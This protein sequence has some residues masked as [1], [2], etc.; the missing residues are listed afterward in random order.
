MMQ[1]RFQASRPPPLNSL[2][3]LPQPRTG[4]RP[5]RPAQPSTLGGGGRPDRPQRRMDRFRDAVGMYSADAIENPPDDVPYTS[6]VSQRTST[7]R[8]MMGIQQQQRSMSQLDKL[9]MA[10]DH[11]MRASPQQSQWDELDD[12]LRRNDMCVELMK[13]PHDVFPVA[14]KLWINLAECDYQRRPMLYGMQDGTVVMPVFTWEEYAN[15]FFLVNDVLESQW[16]PSPRM[17]TALDTFKKLEFPVMGHGNIQKLA[18]LATVALRQ[19][20]TMLI[21]PCMNVSKFLSYQEMTSL[22]MRR[23]SALLSAAS[24]QASTPSSTT[25]SSVATS[26]KAD[27]RLRI[28]RRVFDSR[29]WRGARLSAS[30]LPAPQTFRADDPVLTFRLPLIAS[31]EL[32]LRMFQQREVVRVHVDVVPVS[33]LQAIAASLMMGSPKA[34][35]LVITVVLDEPLNDAA[36]K[37]ATED[38]LLAWS[39]VTEES[40]TRDCRVVFESDNATGGPNVARFGPVVYE[41]KDNGDWLS[42]AVYV[43]HQ[44]LR[45]SLRYDAPLDTPEAS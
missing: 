26:E 41:R 11:T 8:D 39:L 34:T 12:L 20:V 25:S 45:E 10:M 43:P 21:N 40:R 18:S 15:N 42:S 19:P 29:S 36:K 6:N 24:L 28:F 38:N 14:N 13:E 31:T 23:P 32:A 33:K 22:A 37:E 4:A 35:C 27:E 7:V 44:S 9:R 3:G 1:R 5:A 2:K 16:F 30:E 17:G